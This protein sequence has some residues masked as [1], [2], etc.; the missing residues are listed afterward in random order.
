MSVKIFRLQGSYLKLK[1]R[2]L[3]RRE[4]RALTEDDARDQL[5]S[6]LGSFHRVSRKAINIEKIDEIS[7]SEAE[8]HIIQQ[9][10]DVE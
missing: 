2:Y 5:F 9:L 1:R 7:P 8:T 10:S 6:L 4:I 3:F